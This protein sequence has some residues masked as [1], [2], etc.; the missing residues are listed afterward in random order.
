MPPEVRAVTRRESFTRK[1]SG[2]HSSRNLSRGLLADHIDPKE[3]TYIIS[4]T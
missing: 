1:A 4:N 2:R 3:I